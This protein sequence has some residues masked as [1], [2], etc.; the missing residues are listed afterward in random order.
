MSRKPQ[1][2][3]LFPASLAVPVGL[4]AVAGADKSP[5]AYAAPARRGFLYLERRSLL[6]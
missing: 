6:P 3:D 2:I 4:S 5:G 1:R